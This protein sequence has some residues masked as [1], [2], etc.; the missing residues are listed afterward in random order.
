MISAMCIFILKTI[1]NVIV[2]SITMIAKEL[3]TE[4]KRQIRLNMIITGI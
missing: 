3:V 2:A 1:K 4:A